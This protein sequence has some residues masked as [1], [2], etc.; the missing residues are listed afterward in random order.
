MSNAV[1]A[2]VGFGLGVVAGAGGL[3]LLAR[4]YTRWVEQGKNLRTIWV[5]YHPV[6]AHLVAAGETEP[7]AR[8]LWEETLRQ[9]VPPGHKS[10]LYCHTKS[11]Y[12]AP[13]G[14]ERPDPKGGGR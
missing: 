6:G 10:P 13:A 4:A 14:Y 5:A 12:L 8:K 2:V 9:D 11:I 1:S 3:Y 7:A